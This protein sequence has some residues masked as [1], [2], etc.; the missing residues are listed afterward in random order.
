MDVNLAWEQAL[1]TCATGRAFLRPQEDLGRVGER[2][3][4]SL[5]L[6]MRV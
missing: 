4:W 5:E 1:V 3:T 6:I 2:F